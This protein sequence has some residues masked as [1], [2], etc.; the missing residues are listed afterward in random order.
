[1]I[2]DAYGDA[3][4][5]K[6]SLRIQFPKGSVASADLGQADQLISQVF[7]A[8]PPN[9]TNAKAPPPAAGPPVNIRLGESVDEVKG[10]LGEPTKTVDLGTKRIYIY[11]DMKITFKDGKVSDVQ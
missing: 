1:L 10:A 2:S 4:R 8:P 9:N 7:K 11:K 6:G 3:E 5:Y